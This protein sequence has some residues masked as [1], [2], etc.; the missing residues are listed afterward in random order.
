[1]ECHE[2]VGLIWYIN[3]TKCK[4]MYILSFFQNNLYGLR[5]RIKLEAERRL[6][7]NFYFLFSGDFTLRFFCV[8]CHAKSRNNFLRQEFGT[9]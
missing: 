7:E 9:L 5:F 8:L 6:T 2:M 4:S 1:M 3:N